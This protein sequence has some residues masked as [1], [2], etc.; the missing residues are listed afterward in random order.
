M[1]I[2]E[3][4]ITVTTEDLDELNHVNN[5]R[6]IQWANA[7]AKEHW[8]Q[9]TTKDISDNF[10]WVVI[11]HFIEYKSSA[12]LDDTIKLKTY[13]RKT[14]GAKSTRVVEMYRAQTEKLIVKS[15]T[16]WC[17]INSKNLRPSRITTEIASLFD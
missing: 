14:E 13:I 11:S 7:I 5:V 2:F 1:Q 17:L 4:L 9:N 15:E 16:I 10:F 3:K 8:E 6:Y 12:L